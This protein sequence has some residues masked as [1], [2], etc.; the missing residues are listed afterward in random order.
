[1]ETPNEKYA[2]MN[3]SIWQKSMRIL[4]AKAAKDEL[5]KQEKGYYPHDS[6]TQEQRATFEHGRSDARRLAQHE[7]QTEDENTVDKDILKDPTIFKNLA[8]AYDAPAAGN[9]S[10]AKAAPQPDNKKPDA[11]VQ[12]KAQPV[13]PER[14]VSSEAGRHFIPGYGRK[15]A[16]HAMALLCLLRGAFSRGK[17]K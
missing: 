3:E 12:E 11:K 2:Y 14:K 17:I 6:M 4:G 15:P 16:K 7:E 5:S 13:L 8:P 1:M 9:P 10:V